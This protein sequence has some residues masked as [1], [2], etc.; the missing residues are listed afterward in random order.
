[1]ELLQGTTTSCRAR[2]DRDGVTANETKIE[3]IL[4]EVLEC[5]DMSAGAIE[6]T[7]VMVDRGVK[8]LEDFETG[9]SA[10]WNQRTSW[11]LFLGIVP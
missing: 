3:G 9:Y 8:N 6:V 10:P 1:M 5:R 7:Q 4:N 2:L 11:P